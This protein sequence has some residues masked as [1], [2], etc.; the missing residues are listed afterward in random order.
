[1]DVLRK[2][3]WSQK[4]TPKFFFW[5]F[6]LIV[7]RVSFIKIKKPPIASPISGTCQN[8]SVTTP[9][10]ECPSSEMFKSEKKMW[11][12]GNFVLILLY[13][14]T[15]LIFSDQKNVKKSIF[16]KFVCVFFYN[17]TKIHFSFVKSKKLQKL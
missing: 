6:W 10:R 17:L 16:W 3:N 11:Y 4:R 7:L 15:K 8:F 1:M 13:N 5:R 14:L 9:S 12:F 2:K